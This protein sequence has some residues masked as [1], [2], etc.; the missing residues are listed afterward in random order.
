MTGFSE[1]LAEDLREL[2]QNMASQAREAST[3]FEGVRS[4]AE[5]WTAMV[6]GTL[7]G[8]NVDIAVSIDIFRKLRLA[9]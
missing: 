5:A 8:L 6:R 3:Y 7:H 1:G 4:H 2:K 9:N